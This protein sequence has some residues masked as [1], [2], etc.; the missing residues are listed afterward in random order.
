MDIIQYYILYP[1][2]TMSYYYPYHHDYGHSDAYACS[3]PDPYQ[4]SNEDE[5]Q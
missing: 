5:G 4:T 2:Y 1:V 3:C